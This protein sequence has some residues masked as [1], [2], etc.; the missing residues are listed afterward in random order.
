MA[1]PENTVLIAEQELL[2]TQPEAVRFSNLRAYVQTF[3]A[4]AVITLMGVVSGI[5]AAR[6]LGPQGRGELAVIILLPMLLTTIGG[7]ELPRSLAFEISRAKGSAHTLVAT[8][9][10]LAISLGTLQALILLVVLPWYLPSDK[11][12]LIGASCW[13]VLYLPAACVST[14]LMGSDQGRGRFGKFSLFLALPGI[15]YVLAI[16]ALWEARKV[17]PVVF[18]YGVLA[19]GI[20]TAAIRVAIDG[21]VLVRNMPDWAIAKRLLT[22]GLKYYV[23]AIAGFLFSRA[24]MFLV[25]RLLPAEAI[26]LYAVA[27]AIAVGQLVT[28]SPFV[29]VSFAAVAAEHELQKIRETIVHHFRLSQMV[30]IAMGCA[31]AATASWGIRLFFGAGFMGAT[32]ASL[33]LI[34]AT[35]LWAMAQVLDQSFRAASHPRPGIASNSVGLA[36]VF[37]VGIP[38]CLRYGVNGMAGAVL[39]GQIANLAILIGYGVIGLGIDIRRFWAL[40]AATFREIGPITKTLKYRLGWS[41]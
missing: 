1:T 9:F 12:P 11:A 41:Q 34:A 26:G 29:H 36:I 28:V 20:L 7:L 21:K 5:L 40:D 13:F 2:G 32:N 37:A 33:L 22:R 17:T 23:P 31:L 30:A 8:G 4:T 10:W 14:T 39:I 6:L 15:L 35:A 25:V 24:D 3:A 27:Q 18:A 38:G 19:S 16:M